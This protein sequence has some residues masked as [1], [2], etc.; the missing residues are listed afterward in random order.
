MSFCPAHYAPCKGR[1]SL[2]PERIR[3]KPP[4]PR[5]RSIARWSTEESLFSIVIGHAPVPSP[6]MTFSAPLGRPKDALKA[7]MPGNSM[8]Y[9]VRFSP[10]CCVTS[11]NNVSADFKSLPFFWC[12]R[13]LPPRAPLP[14]ARP[15]LKLGSLTADP[16][17]YSMLPPS[18]LVLCR[19]LTSS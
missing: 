17:G 13:L 16:N 11:L 2:M 19:R 7:M 4:R 18:P 14:Q 6:P 8:T 10:F 3:V 5:P 9:S 1:P 12:A 15:H